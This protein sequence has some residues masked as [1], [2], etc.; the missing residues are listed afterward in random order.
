M[1]AQRMAL[2]T[3]PCA[4][5]PET[6]LNALLFQVRRLRASAGTRVEV[7][8]PAVLS[9]VEPVWSRLM[10]WV[11]APAPW[12]AAMHPPGGRRLQRTKADFVAALKDIASPQARQLADRVHTAR[13]P[14]ELWHLRSAVFQLVSL[15]HS[16]RE[17]QV[18]LEALNR[19]FPTRAPRSGFGALDA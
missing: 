4:D 7:C 15:A 11:A 1:H 5:I 13:S 8:P 6:M 3:M 16:Q 12:Q 2:F 14:R 9:P 10:R 19:H 17:A 18:R